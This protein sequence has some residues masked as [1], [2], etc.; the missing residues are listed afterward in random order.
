MKPLLD[1]ERQL[2]A[3]AY[4][5]IQRRLT[6]VDLAFGIV[7][8]ILW[9]AFGWSLTLKA[10]LLSFTG[11]EW[12]LVAGFALV[13]GGILAVLN[14]PLSYYEGF[15][16]P[17]RFGLATQNLRGWIIDQLKAGTISV[18]LGLLILEIIY[19]VLRAYPGYLVAMGGWYPVAFQRHFSQP[20]TGVAF[21]SVL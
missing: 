1:P 17:H 18:I 4:A 6:F 13:F 8:L 20:G 15:V 5:R 3:R 19:A 11:N 12:L 2:Q 21:P 16:L 14:L 10:W 7:Y 9:L